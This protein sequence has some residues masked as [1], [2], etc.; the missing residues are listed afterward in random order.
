[1]EIGEIKE[2]EAN[3]LKFSMKALDDHALIYDEKLKTHV[4]RQVG[5]VISD[6]PENIYGIQKGTKM[7]IQ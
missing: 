4:K 3:G 6:V 7:L 2:L 1:M 5:E